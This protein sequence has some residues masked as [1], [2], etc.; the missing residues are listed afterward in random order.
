MSSITPITLNANGII[1][2]PNYHLK[3]VLGAT[4]IDR[5]LVNVRPKYQDKVEIIRMSSSANSLHAPVVTPTAGV[6]QF[7]I[8]NRLIT[9]GDAMYY[10]EF[11]PIRDFENEYQ[12]QYNRGKLTEAQLASITETAVKELATSDL[13]DG[14]ENLIWNGNTASASPFL[15]RTDGLIKLLDADSDA[16]I[17]N[18]AFGAALTATNILDKFQDMIDACPAAVLEQLNIRFVVSYADLQKYYAAIRDSVITKGI[19]IMDPGVARF[20]GIPI[21]SC[22]IPENKVVLGVFDGGQDGQLQAATWMNEDRSGLLVE[23][24]QNN[25][26]LFFIKALFKWG[27]NYRLGAEIV[28][29]K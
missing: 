11:S 5:G 23:R 25:S 3:A 22:G 18:V 29:G 9:L 17:N 16:D 24:L 19:N 4:T 10:R 6:G 13:A 12:W 7:E 28:Y 21:V 8:T 27:I 26:E 1:P 15:N 2:I 20:A 14:V